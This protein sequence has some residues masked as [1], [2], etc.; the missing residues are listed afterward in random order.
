MGEGTYT[1]LTKAQDA[2][3]GTN[4]TESDTNT[5]TSLLKTKTIPSFIVPV[6]QS[7]D[8]LQ[9]ALVRLGDGKVAFFG[10]AGMF[11]AQIAADWKSKMGMNNE[12]AQHNWKFVLQLMR[13]L[14]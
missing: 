13:F 2:Y 5:L 11:T 1:V 4:S 10:E 7:G 12:Q 9:A 3:F 14:D 6:V 8:K